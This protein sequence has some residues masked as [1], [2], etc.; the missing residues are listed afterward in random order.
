MLRLM[1]ITT[2]TWRI[3]TVTA[4]Q[5]AILRTV[6]PPYRIGVIAWSLG[7]DQWYKGLGSHNAVTASDDVISWQ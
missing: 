7:K 3:H 2:T 6:G 5:V 1:A 4:T